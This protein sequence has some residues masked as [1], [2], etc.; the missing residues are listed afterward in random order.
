MPAFTNVAGIVAGSMGS[1]GREGQAMTILTALASGALDN[2]FVIGVRRHSCGA[3]NQPI[4]GWRREAWRSRIAMP[5]LVRV[6][7]RR[8]VSQFQY[9]KE[10]PPSLRLV[11][12]KSRLDSGISGLMLE[13]AFGKP[14]TVGSQL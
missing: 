2:H 11:G 6:T 9:G 13:N 4:D 5:Q 8:I 14:M 1:A 12:Q 7:E 10:S 3:P